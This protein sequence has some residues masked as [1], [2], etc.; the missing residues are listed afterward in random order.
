M[1]DAMSKVTAGIALD[2]EMLEARARHRAEIAQRAQDGGFDAESL[3]AGVRGDAEKRER[4][5]FI[6]RAAI[7][8]RGSDAASREKW[9]R[10]MDKAVGEALDWAEALWAERERRRLAK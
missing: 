2:L 8:F 6:D 9:P 5:E 1:L 10:S 4:Q 3:I 7:A